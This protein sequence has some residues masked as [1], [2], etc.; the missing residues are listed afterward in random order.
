[1]YHRFVIQADRRVALKRDLAD[2][3]VE[4]AVHYPIPIHLQPVAAAL[5]YPPGSFPVTEHQ[6]GRILSLPIYPELPLD[7]VERVVKS[8]RKFFE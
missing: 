6:A 7:D 4:T 2:R 1:M 3:G 5:G 8:I